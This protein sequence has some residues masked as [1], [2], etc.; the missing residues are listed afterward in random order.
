MTETA[1]PLTQ[2]V[3]C[4]G[5]VLGIYEAPYCPT[6]ARLKREEL[7][8][9]GL[10]PRDLRAHAEAVAALTPR[11]PLFLEAPYERAAHALL[12]AV[13]ETALAILTAPSREDVLE[14]KEALD[15]AIVT[16]QSQS[17]A[18]QDMA[19]KWGNK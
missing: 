3:L 10:T 9:A 14:F 4:D 13:G 17:V 7:I 12:D 15:K 1:R 19:D 6:C 16:L 2:C 8:D 5:Y 18:A 11:G